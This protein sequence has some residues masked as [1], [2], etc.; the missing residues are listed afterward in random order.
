MS[1]KHKINIARIRNMV[2]NDRFLVSIHARERAF[3][4]NITTDQFISVIMDGDVLE[5]HEELIPCPR[6]R[7][8]GIVGGKSLNVIV[9]QCKE[10]IQIVTVYISEDEI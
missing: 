10:I 9:A 6:A 3:Q 2:E 1:K 7:I 4:R 5:R 8:V